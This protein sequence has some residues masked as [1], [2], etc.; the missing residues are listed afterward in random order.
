MRNVPSIYLEQFSR[1]ISAAFSL[2][3]IDFDITEIVVD[4]LF[5]YSSSTNTNPK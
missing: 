1:S 5:M 4:Y 2:Y 3:L